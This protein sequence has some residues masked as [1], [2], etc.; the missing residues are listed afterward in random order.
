MEERSDRVGEPKF[1]YTKGWPLRAAWQG[2][3]M[4]E[5]SETETTPAAPAPSLP[6]AHLQVDFGQ[7]MPGSAHP[8]P[9]SRR[10]DYEAR[11][12]NS[13]DAQ[14]AGAEKASQLFI[15]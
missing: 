12:R 15:R 13:V 5:E 6:A 7:Q 14:A 9:V 11:I 1:L 10:S 2:V 8:M 3:Y 4:T